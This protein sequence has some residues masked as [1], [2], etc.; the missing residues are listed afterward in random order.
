MLFKANSQPHEKAAVECC[1][2]P[3]TQLAPNFSSHRFVLRSPACTTSPLL[4]RSGIG[5]KPTWWSYFLD[6]CSKGHHTA[7]PEFTHD[8]VQQMK[9]F[10][11]GAG[12]E[13]HRACGG[14][15]PNPAGP[16][17]VPAVLPTHVFSSASR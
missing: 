14:F 2:V 1:R 12:R 5:S 15:S 17:P 7:C 4:L 13:P 6:L 11:P 9:R 10:P 3:P 8:P 16:I